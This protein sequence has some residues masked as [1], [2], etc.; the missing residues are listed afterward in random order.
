MLDMLGQKYKS[1]T[2]SFW[3]EYSNN[4]EYIGYGR[5]TEYSNNIVQGWTQCKDEHLWLGCE[6]AAQKFNIYYIA[7][8]L[9]YSEFEDT[10]KVWLCLSF[11]K[12]ECF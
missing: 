10:Q 8:N 3:L 1:Q 7:V 12:Q 6:Y 5:S 2:F 9:I 11:P 4:I